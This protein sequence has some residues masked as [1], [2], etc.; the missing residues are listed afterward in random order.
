MDRKLINGGSIKL[1]L[2]TA[3]RCCPRAPTSRR[4]SSPPSFSHLLARPGRRSPSP[5]RGLLQGAERS[6]HAELAGGGVTTS[7]L[8]RDGG[9]AQPPLN[10][11]T[12][13]RLVLPPSF[14]PALNR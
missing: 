4:T 9:C 11:S 5:R 7:S 13:L 8:R 12:P 6:L 1:Q 14:P 3:R 2:S 10:R